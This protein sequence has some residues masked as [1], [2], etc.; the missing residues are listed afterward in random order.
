M[1]AACSRFTGA[2]NEPSSLMPR[3]IDLTSYQF[4]NFLA[5]MP[6][7]ATL[8]AMCVCVCV[9]VCVGVSHIR[10][11]HTQTHPNSLIHHYPHKGP[12]IDHLTGTSIVLQT[13]NYT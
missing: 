13:H 4:N 10:T 8:I 12:L 3:V 1:C 11:P 7:Y 2:R 5:I 9:C 6:S